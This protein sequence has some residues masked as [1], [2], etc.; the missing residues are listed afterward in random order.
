M[1]KKVNLLP[2]KTLLAVSGGVDSVA[3]CV[4]YALSGN[5]FGIAHAN[6]QL[7]GA[8]SEADATF[9]A[10]L[11]VRYGVS[12]HT[13]IFDTEAIKQKTGGSVQMV[14]RELRYAWFEE[15]RA[16]FGYEL[17]A[18]AHHAGDQV[19]TILQH[20]IRGTGLRGLGGMKEL[21]EARIFRPLLQFTKAELKKTVL[22]AGLTWREDSSNSSLKYGRNYI[23]HEL[24]PILAVQNPNLEQTVG[25]TARYLQEA[26]DLVQWAATN[27]RQQYVVETA[28]SEGLPDLAIDL[29]GI[30]SLPFRGVLLHEWLSPYLFTAS[31][32]ENIQTSASNGLLFDTPTHSATRHKGQLFIRQKAVEMPQKARIEL[33][34]SE[35][36]VGNTI[37]QCKTVGE[38]LQI[39]TDSCELE[40]ALQHLRFPLILR[41][42]VTGERF[43][44]SGMGGK[45]KLLSDFL[46]DEGIARLLRR[47]ALV[48]VDASDEI[49]AVFYA[50][51]VRLAFIE[52]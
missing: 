34:T 8:E 47:E 5:D 38:Q 15:L 21:S 19:E 31:Q 22:E 49:L 33:E 45:R 20:L 2:Q 11:A 25:Q 43:K 9:V 12:F 40:L 10:E 51:K 36:R 39:S 4:Y 1:N 26:Y 46:K 24:V 13:K 48:L 52:A 18:T 6:F 35:I 16:T 30:N 50:N 7:R 29:L 3:M 41:S 32:V 44:P 28:G 42:S 17:V 37:F 27:L 14:A 23:R